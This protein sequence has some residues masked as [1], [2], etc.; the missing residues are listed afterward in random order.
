MNLQNKTYYE[1]YEYLLITNT[2]T[3]LY[4]IEEYPESNSRISAIDTY[5]GLGKDYTKK[6]LMSFVENTPNYTDFSKNDINYCRIICK[7]IE[8]AYKM[9]S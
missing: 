7:E 9:K 2:E 1:Y 3:I 4:Y 8:N 5:Y 6:L